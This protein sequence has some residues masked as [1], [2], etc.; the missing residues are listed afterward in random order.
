LP[1]GGYQLQSGIERALAERGHAALLAATSSIS[2]AGSGRLS[3]TIALA[4]KPGRW[5][6]CLG[7][8]IRMPFASGSGSVQDAAQQIDFC[9]GRQR[10]EEALTD[11]L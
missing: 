4:P 9:A 7:Q 8:R 11:G 1:L 6:R 2:I 5:A 10:V 3:G